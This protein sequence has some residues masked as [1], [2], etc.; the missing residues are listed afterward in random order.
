MNIHGVGCLIAAFALSGTSFAGSLTVASG[1]SKTVS[2][3]ALYDSVTVS[4]TL[5][6]SGAKLTSTA[7]VTVDGG[8]IELG[9]GAVLAAKGVNGGAAD[10]TITFKGGKL[11]LSE[12]IQTAGAGKIALVGDGNDVWLDVR[13]ATGFSYLFDRA[14]AS[15]GSMTISGTGGFVKDGPWYAT[16]IKSYGAPKGALTMSYA[17]DT[18]IAAGGLTVETANPFPTTTELVVKRGAEVYLGGSWVRVRSVSGAGTINGHTDNH[19]KLTLGVPQGSTGRCFARV[20][21]MVDLVKAE[22]GELSVY[23]NLSDSFD[24][25]AGTI[26]VVPRAQVGYSEFRLKVD[27][28]GTVAKTGMQ[29]NE[30]A[31][32]NGDEDVTAGYVETAFDSKSGYNGG[33]AF[34][35]KDTTKWWYE[36]AFDNPADIS[37]PT[38]D[39]AWIE[40]YYADRRIVTGYKLKSQDYGGDVPKSWRLYGRDPNGEWELLDQKINEPTAPLPQNNWS[41]L[42]ALAASVPDGK[43][44]CGTMTFAKGTTLSVLSGTAYGCANL[45]D[46]GATFDFASGAT[47][48]LGVT[49][50]RT[51]KGVVGGAFTKSGSG[52]LTA[53]GPAAASVESVTVKAGALKF[54]TAFIPWKYWKFSFGGVYNVSGGELTMGEIAV[55]DLDGSRLNV[56]GSATMAGAGAASFSAQQIPLLYD[57]KGSTQG[58]L[59]ISSIN[60]DDESTWK[61]SCFTLSASAPAVASYN[62]MTASYEANG[63]PTTWKVY[64]RAAETDDWTLIDTQRDFSSP[65]SSCTWYNNGENFKVTSSA[66]EGAAA[67][68]S[69]TPVSVAPGSTLDLSQAQDTELALI[70]VTGGVTGVGT[71]TGGKLASTGVLELTFDGETPKAPYALPLTLD[72]VANASAIEGWRLTINGVASKKQLVLQASGQVGVNGRGLVLIYK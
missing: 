29:L 7:A 52:E 4:G 2:V 18:V 40:V 42:Y 57:G 21:A 46:N 72:G 15:Y 45:V 54:M 33:A 22:A 19:A 10:S 58:W 36:Y 24:V 39:H 13:S 48:D 12:R 9:T 43:T 55:F 44:T 3:D 68:P 16:L 60:P 61:Y 66:V 34:D 56:T 28:V 65:S 63:R 47:V 5:I 1:E 69:A 38:F 37:K 35:K 14:D 50:D 51:A 20:G 27:G 11:S 17:G 70:R 67:F 64:A 26:K 8:R 30:L 31:L 25:Q 32:F 59:G 71:I 53:Y 62:L 41:P 49:A 6:V 23:G